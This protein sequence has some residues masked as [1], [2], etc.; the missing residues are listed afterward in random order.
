M[1]TKSE[2]HLAAYTLHNT[3]QLIRGGK[4]YFDL[5][6]KLIN[7]ARQSIHF[8]VYIFDEDETGKMIAEALMLAA[9][10]NVRVFLMVDGY[11]STRLS[12][13]FIEQILKAGIQFKM[14][15]PIFFTKHFYFGRR[16]HHK[17]VV[18]DAQHSLV[19]GINISDKYNDTGDNP[20]WLDWGLYV[21]GEAAI[22]LLNVCIR[23]WTR[24]AS[25]A[26]K[27]FS[28]EKLPETL[29]QEKC[30]VRV[31]RNDWVGRLTQ[32]NASYLEMFRKANSHIVIMSSYFL[33]GLI[34][35]QRLGRAAKRGVKI[36]L[37]LAGISDVNLS[38][39]AE[40]Y[41]Y[42]WLLRHNIEI[43]ELQKTILHGKLATYD[44][45]FVTLGSYNV[46]NI[47]AYVS[48]EL[49]LDVREK[50]FALSVDKELE[51]IIKQDCIQITEKDCRHFNFIQRVSQYTAY[52]AIRF[53]Y[54]IS[55]FYFK[56]RNL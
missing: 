2:K 5:L 15:E 13:G 34:F 27:L 10:R 53:M 32:I 36:K 46:N 51:R 42:R 25:K 26:R 31:R 30:M 7:T 19:S 37:I 18:V 41:I 3:P 33:P 14:F 22:E 40:R 55:T 9:K 20:A 45:E 12:A 29:P 16:L 1:P 35:K 49:N 17:V 39:H 8:Q 50:E 43:Y 52:T 48:L 6:L 54:F 23:V 56:Q 44:G 47:S 38:K 4:K 24:S 28:F 11:G 21:E